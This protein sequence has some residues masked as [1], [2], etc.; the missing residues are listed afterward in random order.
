MIPQSLF[1]QLLEIS[2][3]DAEHRLLYLYMGVGTSLVL[4]NGRF[5]D[6]KEW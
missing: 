3:K 6:R 2:F 5:F 4:G 1:S